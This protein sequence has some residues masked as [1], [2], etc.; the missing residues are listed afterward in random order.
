MGR[1]ARSG[2]W[3]DSSAAIGA[4]NDAC[5]DLIGEMNVMEK[6]TTPE[7]GGGIRKRKSARRDTL[8]ALYPS[9][10]LPPPR[11][12]C[13]KDRA[14]CRTPRSSRESRAPNRLER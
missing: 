3:P 13:D 5:L 9:F 8:A 4:A 10:D 11:R 14:R 1:G 6:G 2:V 7:S 12:L